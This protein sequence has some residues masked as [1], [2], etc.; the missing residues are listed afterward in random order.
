MVYRFRIRGTVAPEEAAVL[1]QSVMDLPGV[2]EASVDAEAALFT[3]RTLETRPVTRKTVEHAAAA[4]RVALVRLDAPPGFGRRAHRTGINIALTVAGIAF[5]GAGRLAGGAGADAAMLALTLCAFALCAIPL[6]LEGAESMVRERLVPPDLFVVVV[7][8]MSLLVSRLWDAAVVL[9]LYRVVRELFYAVD[10]CVEMR[11][12]ALNQRAYRARLILGGETVLAPPAALRAGDLI[13]LSPGERLLADAEIVEGEGRSGLPPPFASLAQK[14]LSVGTRVYAG[15]DIRAGELTAKVTSGGA[16]ALE[17]YQRF[18]DTRVLGPIT[19]VIRVACVF[20]TPMMV[21]VALIVAFLGNTLSGLPADE[22]ISRALVI[23]LLS[24]AYPAAAVP[25]VSALAALDRGLSRGV[26]FTNDAAVERI[27]AARTL[28]LD[29]ERVLTRGEYAVSSV[30]SAVGYASDEVLACAAIAQFTSEGL[31]PECLRKAWG[32]T[33]DESMVEAREDI[34]GEGTV[35]VFNGH[36]LIAGSARLME[37]E[38]V[39]VDSANGM[40]VYVLVDGAYAGSVVVSDPVRKDAPSI[41]SRLKQLGVTRTVMFTEEN[42]RA[43]AVSAARASVDSY[44]IVTGD[45]GKASRLG[46]LSKEDALAYVG[47]GAA[48]S[49]VFRACDAS[50]AIGARLDEAA[51]CDVGAAVISGGLRGLPELFSIA[52]HFARVTNACA[53]AYFALSLTGAALAMSGVLS[54]VPA[55]AAASLAAALC[56]GIAFRGAGGEETG[57]SAEKTG[58]TAAKP[59]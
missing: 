50:V 3:V 7:T 49:P 46:S 34:P 12:F 55:L 51:A 21:A 20:Y 16:T 8:G 33:V 26:L 36:R 59:M 52:R 42:P 56:M 10:P 19:R 37:R 40:A 53:A 18:T 29:K 38:G 45:A 4:L 58:G 39:E 48:R 5:V 25:A 17:I 47:A 43:A 44:E 54:I 13:R 22:C 41:L 15:S 1:T 31:L 2:E 32:G 14:K 11:N 24:C 30:L 27:A 35:C 9:L 23:G 57:E 28:V 6:V